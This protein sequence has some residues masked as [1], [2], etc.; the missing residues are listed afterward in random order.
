VKHPTFPGIA[1]SEA[2]KRDEAL[3]LLE[4]TRANLIAAAKII[5]TRIARQNGRVT[6]PEVL[7]LLRE[8]PAW[9]GLVAEVDPRFMGPVFRKGWTRIGYSSEG[10]H[11]RPVAVWAL[12]GTEK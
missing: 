8:S 6:S 9:A 12:K 5:A 3:A 7:K 10:S 11:N 4:T 2:E 1:P